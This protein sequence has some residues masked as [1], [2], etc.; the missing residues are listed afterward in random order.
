MTK[1]PR[2]RHPKVPKPTSPKVSKSTT[3][4]PKSQRIPKH[5]SPNVPKSRRLELSKSH[6]K[7]SETATDFKIEAFIVLSFTD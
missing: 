3:Q 2:V 5:S 6:L 4:V 7:L 1:S